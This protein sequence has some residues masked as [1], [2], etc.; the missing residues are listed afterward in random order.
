MYNKNKKAQ[1]SFEYIMVVGLVFITLMPISY[2]YL[3]YNRETSIES[4]QAQ[5]DV[6]GKAITQEAQDVFYSGGYT[7]RTLNYRVPNRVV[8]IESFEGNRIVFT[9]N[10][11]REQTATY[12]SSVPI[13][14]KKNDEFGPER[15]ESITKFIVSNK[16]LQNISVCTNLNEDDC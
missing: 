8:D 9:L 11:G 3:S 2:F 7:K 14:F 4:A 1:Y 15:I 10:I 16:N 13:E 5:V 12:I 6:I